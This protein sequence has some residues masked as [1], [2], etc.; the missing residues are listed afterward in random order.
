MFQTKEAGQ[1]Q[2]FEYEVAYQTDMDAA[3]VGG[4]LI[5]LGL[6]RIAVLKMFNEQIYKKNLFQ[7]LLE[8]VR[9]DP[10]LLAE[11][12]QYARTNGKTTV[13][14]LVPVSLLS[15]IYTFLKQIGAEVS[16]RLEDAAVQF[17]SGTF[18]AIRGAGLNGAE[19]IKDQVEGLGKI[20][21]GVWDGMTSPVGS[22]RFNKGWSRTGE[23]AGQ[24]I[25]GNLKAGA[26]TLGDAIL[27]DGLKII[28]GWQTLLG[29][30]SAGRLLTPA[31]AAIL[32]N[33]FGGSVEL[34]A[35]RIKTGYSGVFSA[36]EDNGFKFTDNQRAITIGNTIYMKNAV[37]GSAGWDSTLV[38][39]TTHVWQFQNGGTDYMGEAVHAQFTAGYG[40]ADDIVNK[41][42]NWR[43]LNPEQQAQVIQDAHD[44]GYFK[45]GGWSNAKPVYY[46]SQNQTQ[47]QIQPQFMIN[48]LNQLM[49]QLRAGQGA[50]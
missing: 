44:N 45:N 2:K 43:M 21:E 4:L 5:Q 18:D 15:M 6:G 31:E 24:L 8:A 13:S 37:E 49:P 28:S 17:G 30:E 10:K 29:F 40:Y 47:A 36:G 11:H 46:T 41:K 3:I 32:K 38:H 27:F 14:F 12:I 22:D 39:E 26:Q 34:G 19:G 33:V 35:I 23:G 16:K 42:K 20:G 48:Y 7:V 25:K 50:T 1:K 9:S